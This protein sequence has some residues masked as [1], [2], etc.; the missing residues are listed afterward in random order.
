VHFLSL[1]DF[2]SAR[3]AQRL[4]TDDPEVRAILTNPN[5][6]PF[7]V[8][9][10][11]PGDCRAGFNPCITCWDEPEQ[12]EAGTLENHR[13]LLKAYGTFLRDV[14][15][16]SEPVPLT[17]TCGTAATLSAWRFLDDHTSGSSWTTHVGRSWWPETGESRR[18]TS[19][20]A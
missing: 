7:L 3:R 17:L 1:G 20:T 11:F 12:E 10:K 16:L 8:I 9:T 4:Q 19:W 13:L 5:E 15:I 2:R 6:V 18:T 14:S